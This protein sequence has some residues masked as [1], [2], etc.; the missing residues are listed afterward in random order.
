MLSGLELAE[1]GWLPDQ[2]IRI[3]IRRLLAA[4]LEE[5][6]RLG[7]EG[8]SELNRSFVA[9]LRKSPIALHTSAANQQH[10]EV[11]SAYFE[12]VLGPHRK[13]SSCL[14]PDEVS[15]LSVAEQKML[16]LTCKR[17]DLHDGMEILELGCGWGSLSLFMA[18]QYPGS[19]FLAVSNS[20]SQR[21]FILKQAA[22]RGISNLV[23]ET[24]DMNDFQ[25]DRT[26][27]RV[28]SV[29]MFEH[30]R[31]YEELFA[32]I[33]SWLK[34]TGK[35][36][37]HVFY[38]GRCAYPFETDG[39]NDWMARHFFTGGL[40]PSA[41]LFLEFQRD[42][43]FEDRWLINGQHY[44]K[45]LEA[46]LKRHDA[47]REQ[48]LPLFQETYGKELAN[49]MFQRWRL[50]YLA[51]AELFGYRHGDEWGVAHFLFSRREVM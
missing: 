34:P 45:T 22:S 11:P 50:F 12:L 36:F 39:N 25:T 19:R 8:L 1:H 7:C 18:R 13:Y 27:D 17:A 35:L 33:A 47:S 26:F 51:C 16:E 48:I 21:E 3:G 30:M 2:L 40:M 14:W 31:N 9:E 32:R 29:E 38:H 4:R 44:Q 24:H 46:W 42:L 41:E 5:E 15:E 28:V 20:A 37:A 49:V 43:L 10:Y 23:V 6:S